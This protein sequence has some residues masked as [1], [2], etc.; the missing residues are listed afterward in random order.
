MGPAKSFFDLT[1]YKKDLTRFWPLWALYT[2]IWLFILPFSLINEYV[3]RYGT[4]DIASRLERWV[5]RT[6][7]RIVGSEAGVILALFVGVLGAMAVWS[8]L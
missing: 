1:L 7:V 2:V 3:N 5:N 6:P 8:Y 4:S